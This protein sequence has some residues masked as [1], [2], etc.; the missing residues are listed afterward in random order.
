MSGWWKRIGDMME[1][2]FGMQ[3]EKRETASMAGH[4]KD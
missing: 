4:R 1:E 3:K 2:R